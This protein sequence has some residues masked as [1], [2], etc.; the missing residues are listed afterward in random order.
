MRLRGPIAGIDD[1]DDEIGDSGDVG[2][3]EDDGGDAVEGERMTDDDMADGPGL[4][5]R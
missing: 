2:V 5:V 1:D 4:S 3:D